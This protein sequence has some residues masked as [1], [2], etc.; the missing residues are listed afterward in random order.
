MNLSLKRVGKGTGVTQLV[1]RVP[2]AT[3]RFDSWQHQ[4][5]VFATASRPALG[6][7]QPPV[8]WLSGALSPDRE[9]NHSPPSNAEVK[10]AWSYTS[11]TPHVFS[12]WHL[13]KYKNN[14]TFAL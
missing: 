1:T 3:L 9:A 7:T 5:L 8:Q 14:F 10:N 6:P 11:T 13:V 4:E 2:A 12:P